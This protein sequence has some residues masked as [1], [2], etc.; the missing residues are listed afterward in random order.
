MNRSEKKAFVESLSS[1]LSESQ[2][3]VVVRHSGINSES[4]SN[5]RKVARSNDVAFSVVKNSLLK[6]SVN[7]SMSSLAPD[8]TEHVR[9]GI[10]VFVSSDALSASRVAHQCAK[11][12]KD[13]M[14]VVIGVIEGEVL[15][16]GR[17]SYLATLPSLDEMR[18]ILLRT[19]LAQPTRLVRVLK[20]YGETKDEQQTG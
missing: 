3:F 10:G 13:N 15:D 12:N 16:A 5:L 20:K 7:N 4:M 1:S 8:I 6:L 14:S 17:V 11:E 19:M 18:S 9:G 2:S